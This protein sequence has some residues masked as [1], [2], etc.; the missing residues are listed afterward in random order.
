MTMPE[1]KAILVLGVGNSLLT[2]DGAGLHVLAELQRLGLP[3]GMRL[4]DGGTIGLA[5]LTEIEAASALIAVDACELKAAPGTLRVFEGIEMDAALGGSKRTAHE[6][7]LA[8]LLDAARLSG[9]LPLRRALVGVQPAFTGW[10][11]LPGPE[12]AE[13]IPRAA[14]AVLAL[15]DAWRLADA[16]SLAD[17]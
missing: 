13:A 14:A 15:A 10:G 8:D 9:A 3:A 17:A 5:L 11:L 16:G 6:V 4:C 1:K 2:D 12:V 7:A